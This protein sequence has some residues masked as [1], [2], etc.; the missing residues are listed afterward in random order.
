MQSTTTQTPEQT[1]TTLPDETLV[2]Y[3]IQTEQGSQIKAIRLEKTKQ[4]AI[5]NEITIGEPLIPNLAIQYR[6]AHFNSFQFG[7]DQQAA[8]VTAYIK[9]IGIAIP[10]TD[11]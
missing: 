7:P 11:F 10:T 2:S 9:P 8:Q 5:G 6:I 4:L 3:D 1:I